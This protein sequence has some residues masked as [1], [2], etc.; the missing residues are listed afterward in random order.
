MDSHDHSDIT[1]LYGR[2][3]HCNWSIKAKSGQ[4]SVLCG[5]CKNL[6]NIVNAQ[7]V[8]SGATPIQKTFPSNQTTTS[9]GCLVVVT[10]LVILAFICMSGGRSTRNEP[11]D[12]PLG[13]DRDRNRQTGDVQNNPCYRACATRM[14]AHPDEIAPQCRHVTPASEYEKCIQGAAQSIADR[15]LKECGL[16]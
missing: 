2:C 14:S 9:M 16:K 3:P 12:A 4:E 15:C 5:S 11:P 8:A 10:I 7:F 6:V 1:G 13:T